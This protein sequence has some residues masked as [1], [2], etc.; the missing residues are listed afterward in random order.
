MRLMTA[1]MYPFYVTKYIVIMILQLS[2]VHGNKFTSF[3]VNLVLNFVYKDDFIS[4]LFRFDVTES[5]PGK[6]AK[7]G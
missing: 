1:K 5:T 6:A 4:E 7:Q 3:V 2:T